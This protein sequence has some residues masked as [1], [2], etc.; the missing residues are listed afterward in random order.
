MNGCERDVTKINEFDDYIY[1]FRI[2]SRI[3]A[4]VNNS[5]GI[6]AERIR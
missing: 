3:F 2:L 6:F 5:S 4:I 1:V